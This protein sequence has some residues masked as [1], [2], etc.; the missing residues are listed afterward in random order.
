M[1]QFSEINIAFRVYENAVDYYGI[2]DV[3]LPDITQITEEMQGAGFAGKYDA[4]II[5]HIEAMKTTIN[6]RNPTKI[7]YNLFT[8]VEHQLDLRANVQERD[9]VSGVRQVAV[10]HILKCTPITLKTGKL[11]N[12]STGDTNA[13]YA[14]HYF[15]TFIDG[16]KTLEVDPANYIFFVDGV[17]YLAEMRKNL[18]LQRRERPALNIRFSFPPPEWGRNPGFA[19]SL[20]QFG[21]RNS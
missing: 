12:F 15:A 2:A 4:V 19:G 5:G 11:A 1:A 16:A 8:P 18:G 6:F 21:I 7:A 9:T 3:D 17:D 10:K 13:E 14:V 20:E